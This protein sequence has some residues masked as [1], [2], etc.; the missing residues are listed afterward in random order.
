MRLANL[1]STTA[2]GLLVG[3]VLAS[4]DDAF[5]VDKVTLRNARQ[6]DLYEARIDGLLQT[7]E[8]ATVEFSLQHTK[9]GSWAKVS[10][11]GVIWGTPDKTSDDRVK[12]FVKATASDRSASTLV[13]DIPVRKPDQPMVDEL[14]VLTW[15]LWFGG[16]KVDDYYRKQVRFLAERDVDIV[17]FQE[18]TSD[19]A[20]R[21]ARAFGWYVFQ[22]KDVGIA[23]KYPIVEQYA[24]AD[25]R[26]AVRIALDGDDSQINVW[27]VHLGYTPYGPYD[28][29]F[30]HLNVSEVL[31]NEEKSNRTPQIKSTIE[32]MDEQ[33]QDA[34]NIP[35]LLMGDF[36][37]PS[38]LDWI[39]ETKDEHCGQG[40]MAWPTSEYPVKAGLVDSFREVNPDP[41]EEP[42]V[43]WSPIYKDNEGR[44]EPE[45][46]IDIIYHK[47]KIS[48][49]DA[50]TVVEGH[51]KPQ[52][53]HEHN[54]WTSDHSAVLAVFKV[55]ASKK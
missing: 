11:D 35:V 27:N 9:G 17:G 38:H 16:T 43:T 14:R 36:N 31:E 10:S 13:A 21:L 8:N 52:P 55:A 46:R 49:K 40:D 48:A 39:E 26:G 50:Y 4:S 24:E 44:K 19:H 33:L 15:N 6:G 7:G 32:A 5:I 28:F 22:G 23:S 30:D 54:K 3:N 53:Y 51:P 41:L 42:G 47:G 25:Y 37:A 12:V 1:L 20:T 18:S 34:D 2:S 29:C 45:D